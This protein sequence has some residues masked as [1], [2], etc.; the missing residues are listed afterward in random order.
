MVSKIKY[1]KFPLLNF[2]SGKA[3]TIFI[4][5]MVAFL[6]SFIAGLV[7]NFESKILMGF[8]GVYIFTG[9]IKQFFISDT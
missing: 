5:I 2:Y 3:N 4:F 9:I 1:P 8:T 7:Y 6:F